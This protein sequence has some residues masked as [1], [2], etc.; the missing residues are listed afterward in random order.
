MQLE[1]LIRNHRLTQLALALLALSLAILVW[2]GANWARARELAQ[3]ESSSRHQLNL[4]VSHIQGQLEKYEFLPELLATNQRLV[5]LLKNPKDRDRIKELNHY[6]ETINR[7][8]GASDTYLMDSGGLTIAASN[9]NSPRPFVG[10]NYSYRPYFQEAMRG[11]LGRYFALGT[12]S[13][14]R[15]YY[16]AYPVRGDDDILGA[17]VIKIDMAQVEESWARSSKNQFIVTDPDGVVFI[18]TNKRWRYNTMESLDSWAQD[19][20]EESRRYGSATLKP[21]PFRELEPLKEDARIIRVTDPGLNDYLEVVQ[22]M[23]QAG[24]K[25]HILTRIAPVTA[26]VAR[27]VFIAMILIAIVV[28]LVLYLIQRQKRVR[29]RA[30][31]ERRSKRALQQNEE[32]IRS[33]LENTQ[34]GLITMSLNGAIEHVNGKA[35]EMFGYPRG[36]FCGLAFHDCFDASNREQVRELLEAGQGDPIE[37]KARRWDGATFP[38]EMTLGSLPLHDGR[39]RL[40]T[41]HDISA[42]KHQEEALRQAQSLLEARVDE[43]TCDLMESNQKLLREI[44]EHKRTEQALRQA[45]NEL[46]QAAKMAALGQMSTGISHEL[47]QPLAAIRS[48]SDNARALLDH[49][50]SDDARWNLQQISELTDRM[51]RI[52]SQLKQFARK[53]TGQRVSVSL[54]AVVRNSLQLLQPK[55]RQVDA[56]IKVDLPDEDLHVLADMVQLEQVCVNLLANALQAVEEQPE[57]GRWIEVK[58]DQRE[59]VVELSVADG[60]KGIANEH[61]ER[62]FDPFFTTKQKGDGLGLGLSISYRIIEDMGGQ[63]RCSNNPDGGAVFSFVLP[64][65]ET[66]EDGAE[67]DR[68]QA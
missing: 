6:L 4:Y 44:S 17:V 13:N 39:R 61:M 48:Y 68:M 18:T 53:T 50:R 67:I 35:Y 41:L 58:V 43:R 26:Q 60:G 45:Q 64:L 32:R 10:R 30:R 25:V 11:R 27:L 42:L 15:G 9:W 3:L 54:G 12:V 28:L 46:I 63:L 31:Y 8:T 14:R 66:P 56:A 21:F 49:H 24:W 38:V 5:Y 7:I 51:A 57:Q 20:I 40:A 1:F 55:I 22:S 2:F 37:L 59:D 34:A 47:N 62:V 16:F 52:S 23:P 29:E 19:R 65:A 33:I 36:E